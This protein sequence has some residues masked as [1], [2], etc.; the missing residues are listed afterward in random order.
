MSA[1]DTETKNGSDEATTDTSEE[2]EAATAMKK[3][4]G[5]TPTDQITSVIGGAGRWHLEKILL[6]FLVSIP[7]V[8]HIFVT[9]F[10]APKTDFWCEEELV[11]TLAV[12]D[13]PEHLKV[14]ILTAETYF[15]HL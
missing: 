1:Q 11:T 4:G 2:N 15:L 7:G 10:V 6:V 3:A 5:D 14:N 9:A 8:A 13:L 12:A